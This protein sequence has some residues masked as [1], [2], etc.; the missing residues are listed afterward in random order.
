[1][2]REGRMIAASMTRTVERACL[3]P[4]RP[5][6]YPVFLAEEGVIAP[7]GLDVLKGPITRVRQ[8]D[9][10]R[11]VHER[12]LHVLGFR[13][14]LTEDRRLLLDESEVEP[15]DTGKILDKLTGAQNEDCIIRA[16]DDGVEV[17]LSDDVVEIDEPVIFAGSDEPS[18][19]G[20]W[21]YRILPKLIDSP[22]RD[23]PVLLYNYAPWMNALAD[24]VF[25]GRVRFIGHPI[26]RTCRL[27]EAL[28]PSLRNVDVYFDAGAKA[29]YEGI[30]DIQKGRSGREKIYLSRRGQTIRPLLNEAAL[31]ERLGALGFHIVQPEKL[32]FPD[33]IALMRDARVIVCPGGSGLFSTVFA[34]AAEF[35]LDL[36]AGTDWLYAHHNLLRSTAKRHTI[37]FGARKAGHYGPHAP[38]RID[39]DAVVQAL[40][41]AA[42]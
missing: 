1:M 15:F 40:S 17:M 7:P 2:T 6:A 42:A 10:F 13:T 9:H 38:W 36:E 4:P 3:S 25:D 29:F 8:A 12:N 30:A 39:V 16:T 11:L 24:Q 26:P 37:L 32:S 5:L 21:L 34:A 27:R 22:Y 35:V 33:Q 14:L 18:N 19:F 31:E 20:S 41:H 28:V 23:Y